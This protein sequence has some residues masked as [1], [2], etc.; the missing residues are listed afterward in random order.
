MVEL[1]NLHVV[2]C[3]GKDR[4]KLILQKRKTRVG[5]SGQKQSLRYRIGSIFIMPA[6]MF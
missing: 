5:K 4:K 2:S 3:D 6:E 1:Q